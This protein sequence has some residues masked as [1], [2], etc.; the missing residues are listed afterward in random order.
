[1]I[2]L[3]R[4][5]KSI[6][7][8]TGKIGKEKIEERKQAEGKM[9]GSNDNIKPPSY[10]TSKQKNIFKNIVAELSNTGILTNVDNY[11]LTTCAI[12]IDRLQAIETIINEDITKLTNKDIMSAK[13]K[14]TKD[15]FKSFTEL[16]LTPA[17]RAKIGS[18]NIKI[19]EEEQD[20]V[21]KVLRG[22]N[23]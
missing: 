8:S 21:L 11:V 10:L 1:M 2:L 16:S 22:G 12:A 3:A 15:L 6:E 5:C 4:P 19:K 17:A 13:D 23:K 20:Q 18:I 14:Y 9:R 7:T